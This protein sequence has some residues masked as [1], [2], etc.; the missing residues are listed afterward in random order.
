[1]TA[2]PNIREITD[3]DIEPVIN[4]LTRGFPNP[5]RYWQTGLERLRTRNAPS[6][7]PR[8]GYMLDAAGRPVGV[9]LSISSLRWMG[10]RQELFSNL[11]SWYVEPA[12]RSFANLLYKHALANKRTTYLNVSAATNVRPIVEAFGFKRYS[13]GQVL[14][15]PALVRNRHSMRARIIGTEYFDNAVLKDE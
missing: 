6:D 14:A 9:I 13:Q 11:S 5:R 3:A 12:F 10:D 2:K 4:L 7:M 8:Y 1:M 15:M